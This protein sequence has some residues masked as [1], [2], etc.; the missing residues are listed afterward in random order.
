MDTAHSFFRAEHDK[1]VS[2]DPQMWWARFYYSNAQVFAIQEYDAG[3]P[4]D[5]LMLALIAPIPRLL[6]HDKPA[7]ESGYD[8]YR[9]LTGS[10]TSSFGIGFFVEAYWNGGW[11]AVILCSIMLGWLLG[12]VTVSLAAQ[13]AVGN[14]WALPLA[15]LWIRIG[16]RVDGWVHT[17]IAGPAIFT[18]L[19]LGLIRGFSV[20]PSETIRFERLQYIGRSRARSG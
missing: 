13:Q 16:S 18:L 19:F 5:S 6:W 1:Q 17:E 10:N 14:L 3:R 20:V 11:L 15:F 8:F 9:R 12:A 7:I 2:D 4:G